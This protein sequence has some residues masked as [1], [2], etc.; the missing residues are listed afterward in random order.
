M[1]F[2]STVDLVQRQC[3]RRS[4]NYSEMRACFCVRPYRAERPYI[5]NRVQKSLMA[6]ACMSD[7]ITI[8]L[9]LDVI[10]LCKVLQYKYISRESA[11]LSLKKSCNIQFRTEITFLHPK[12]YS[13]PPVQSQQL[14]LCPSV[15]VPSGNI[16]R[17]ADFPVR[18]WHGLSS[19]L[20]AY[21]YRPD[22]NFRA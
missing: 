13:F 6:P 16:C 8:F 22:N 10:L 2:R 17:H 3:R 9:Y 11:S 15:P 1:V 18:T 19:G 12:D 5:L 14:F 7:R 21:I 4:G 20:S